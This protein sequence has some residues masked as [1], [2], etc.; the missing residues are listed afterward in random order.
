MTRIN[1]IEPSRLTSKHLL[2]EYREMLRLRHAR[3]RQTGVSSYRLGKGHVLFFYD[4]GSYLLQRHGQ[5]RDEMKRRGMSPNF[6]LDLSSWPQWAMGDWIPGIDAQ[7]QNVAR[8]I[9]RLANGQE[10]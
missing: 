6:E 8:I 9:N 4:K 10:K 7:L 2:A 1:C 3:P 5:L